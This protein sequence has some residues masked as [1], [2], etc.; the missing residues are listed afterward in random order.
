MSD[1][2]NGRILAFDPT[3]PRRNRMADAKHQRSG[4]AY[5]TL[6]WVLTQTPSVAD[7][8]ATSTPIT[9]QDFWIFRREMAAIERA[10]R[11]DRRA[12]RVA[13][14]EAIRRIH[15]IGYSSGADDE[16]MRIAA[17]ARRGAVVR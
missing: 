17:T 3:R 5:E 11:E 14:I 9:S 7:D 16:R 6:S 1:R 13:M 12:G 2:E 4:L 15:K 10:Q 8:D